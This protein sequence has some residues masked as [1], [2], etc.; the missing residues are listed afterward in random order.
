MPAF[1]QL[2]KKVQTFACFGY[3]SIDVCHIG[4]SCSRVLHSEMYPVCLIT[5]AKEV[6]FLPDFVCLS[7]CV[8]AKLLAVDRGSKSYGRIDKGLAEVCALRVLSLVTCAL[9]CLLVL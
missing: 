4:R 6:M 1:F 8:L 9:F 2:F 7:V 5:S 3:N